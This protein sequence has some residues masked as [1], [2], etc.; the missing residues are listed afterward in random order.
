LKDLLHDWINGVEIYEISK[1]YFSEIED[2][3]FQFEQLGDY[4][5]KYFEIFL[6]QFISNLTIQINQSLKESSSLL[7]FPNNLS[8]FIKWGVG[9]YPALELISNGLAYRVISMKIANTFL[10]KHLSISILEW[11]KGLSIN[12][13]NFLF[14][15]SKAEISQLLKIY[16][17]IQN[18]TINKLLESGEIHISIEILKSDIEFNDTI[19]EFKKVENNSEKLFEIV[20]QNKGVIGIAR[21]ESY[22]Q[23]EA[24]ISLGLEI[25]ITYISE[26]LEGKLRI[27]LDEG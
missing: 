12:E 15:P 22:Y 4:I 24:I 25:K 8:N 23:L 6:N 9:N 13:I 26:N 7:Q 1:K 11:I 14:S 19:F 20:D 3:D 2:V 18:S 16:D 17:G 10:S 21:S 27:S 5:Y